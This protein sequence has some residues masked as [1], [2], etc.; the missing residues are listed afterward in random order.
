MEQITIVISPNSLNVLQTCARKYEY[1]KIR[2]LGQV[3]PKDEKLERG[4]LIHQ[5]LDFYY[6]CIIR[7]GFEI[8]IHL[9]T[10]EVHDPMMEGP[11]SCNRAGKGIVKAEHGVYVEKA[12]EFGRYVASSM[13]LE[14]EAS[15]YF[16]N[17]ARDYLDYQ[18]C[19]NW[20]PLHS[21]EPFSIIFYEDE[22]LRIVFEGKIDLIIEFMMN[23]TQMAWVDHKSIEKSYEP[24]PLDNQ[25]MGYAYAFKEIAT[26]GFVNQVGLQKTLPPEKK[27]KPK[28][29]TYQDT[30]LTEWR[31]TVIYH[32][33]LLEGYIRRNYFPMNHS[34]C[35]FC[36]YKDICKEPPN[37]RERMIEAKYVQ[38]AP[39]DLFGKVQV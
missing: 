21:E 12:I 6:R 3:G 31:E 17:A 11:C 23:V 16:L 18:Q 38:M 36:G 22:T 25:F 10:C 28:L 34:A 30:T 13:D 7:G 2:H 9:E 33:K 26:K 4:D 19:Y 20:K 32:V 24:T 1:Y 15:E 39:H 27:F 29:I 35:K 14:I 5:V 8:P 37:L